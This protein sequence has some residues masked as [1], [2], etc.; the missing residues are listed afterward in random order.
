MMDITLAVR[1]LNSQLPLKAR[2]DRLD[3]ALKDIHQAI[4]HSLV[5][6]GRPPAISELREFSGNADINKIV[7]R[8][9][10]DDLVVLD[11]AGQLVVG[12][13]P[14][15][16]EATP[17]RIAVH[18]HSIFAMCALD[19]VSVAPMFHTAVRIDSRCHVT[20]EAI[21]ITMQD[22]KILSVRPSA[23]VRIGVRWQMPSGT[24]A[25]S[26]CTEMVFLLNDRIANEWQTRDSENISLFDLPQA[27]EFGKQFFTPLLE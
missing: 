14:V 3:Q 4:L 12:A 11:T 2:Q 20:G 1:R 9:R 16:V 21:T 7:E 8:L 25:H 19:A 10:K 18:G 26:M 6:N 23:A 22:T 24:A 5:N 17:H 13:Y 27:V 15:T